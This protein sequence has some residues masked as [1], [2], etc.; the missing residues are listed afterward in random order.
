ML[1]SDMVC[2]LSYLGTL[3]VQVHLL[4]VHD[5]FVPEDHF[6][7][8]VLLRDVLRREVEVEG[9]D[10]PVE[11]G[12]EVRLEIEVDEGLVIARVVVVVSVPGQARTLPLHKIH[13]AE[14]KRKINN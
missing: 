12:R 1:E 4:S 6:V 7:E 10:V 14:I 13:F 3:H 2:S 8:T 11:Q 5:Y 9:L